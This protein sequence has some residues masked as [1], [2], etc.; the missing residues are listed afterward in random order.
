MDD[1]DCNPLGQLGQPTNLHIEEGR[2]RS[3]ER[4]TGAMSNVVSSVTFWREIHLEILQMEWCRSRSRDNG[5]S[6]RHPAPLE[7]TRSVKVTA[8]WRYLTGL[9]S[10]HLGV[11]VSQESGSPSSSSS[12]RQQA[13]ICITSL[14]PAGNRL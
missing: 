7:P 2:R 14:E 9:P 12:L 5:G 4:G 11:R 3:E 6:D 13:L 8:N 10:R 1:D